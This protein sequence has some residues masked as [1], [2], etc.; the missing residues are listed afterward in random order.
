MC[1]YSLYAIPNR[2]AIEG[3][4]LA[5]YMFQTH[6]IGLASIEEFVALSRDRVG[7][8][9]RRSWYSR[10]KNCLNPASR[11]ENVT[12]G[13]IPDGARLLAS[14]F[15]EHVRTKFCL[16]S[17]EVITFVQLSAEPYQY[18]DAIQF[19]TGRCVRLQYLD[20]GVRFRVLSLD[21]AQPHAPDWG[22]HEVW[23][24]LPFER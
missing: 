14:H 21:S 5:T 8:P 12:A 15:P 1:E 10:F 11:K 9:V 3:E 4:Q 22:P 24:T 13:C 16:D 23:R 19:R 2:L 17:A 18:C 7:Q 20:E 6:S